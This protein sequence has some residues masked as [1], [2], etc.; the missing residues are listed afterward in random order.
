MNPTRLFVLGGEITITRDNIPETFRAGQCCEVPAG[1]MHTEQVGPCRKQVG[2][3]GQTSHRHIPAVR[4]THN[5]N[6]PRFA[7]ACI[8][9]MLHARRD[10]A[11]GVIAQCA[12]VEVDKRFAKT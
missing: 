7:H 6:T 9:H 10:V 12:V 8:D 2:I 1:C 4:P 3:V 11:D 5:P